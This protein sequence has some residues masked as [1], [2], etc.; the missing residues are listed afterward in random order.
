MIGIFFLLCCCQHPTLCIALFPWAPGIAVIAF[1]SSRTTCAHIDT[2]VCGDTYKQT[3]VVQPR[4]RTK[5]WAIT[6]YF[7]VP[8]MWCTHTFCISSCS[9]LLLCNIIINQSGGLVL[10]AR[11]ITLPTL[12]TMIQR[13]WRVRSPHKRQTCECTQFL[14][15]RLQSAMC[16]IC[17][18]QYICMLLSRRRKT[19]NN[20][21]I[22]A[23]CNE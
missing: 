20:N 3:R 10:P 14:M 21:N 2:F 1:I 17:V 18:F 23:Y 5:A 19:Y 4:T 9:F 16:F 6:F 12:P 15:C 13:A 22:A 7:H 8:M 11:H